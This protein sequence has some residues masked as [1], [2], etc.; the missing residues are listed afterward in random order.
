MLALRGDEA[1]GVRVFGVV[2]P[3]VYERGETAVYEFG[4]SKPYLVKQYPLE[5]PNSIQL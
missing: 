5:D 4:L 3:V 1:A 2:S